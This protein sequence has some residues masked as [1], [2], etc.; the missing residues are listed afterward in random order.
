MH[1]IRVE[2]SA[3]EQRLK[4]TELKVM[5]VLLCGGAVGGWKLKGKKRAQAYTSR[6]IPQLLRNSIEYHASHA[7][8]PLFF[9]RHLSFDFVGQSSLTAHA[10]SCCKP[11]TTPSF[12][13]IS[14]LYYLL[15]LFVMCCHRL[16]HPQ[17]K[18]VAVAQGFLSLLQFLLI[19]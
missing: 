12:D 7:P 9:S 15:P 10:Y 6:V 4:G 16:H 19:K 14:L 5:M 1:S 17:F 3:N 8:L 11:S 13:C 2:G 18:C